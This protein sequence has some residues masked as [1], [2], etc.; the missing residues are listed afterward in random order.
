MICVVARPPVKQTGSGAGEIEVVETH[1]I[2]EPYNVL[3]AVAGPDG[4]TSG[5]FSLNVSL[6]K[7]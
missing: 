1:T 4:V 2:T 7:K 6:D 5:A 3:I